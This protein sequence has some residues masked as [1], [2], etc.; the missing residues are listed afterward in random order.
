MTIASFHLVRERPGR[1]P[2]AMARLATDRIRLHGVSGLRFRRLLGTGRGDDTAASIDPRRTAMFAV[3]EDEEALDRF[4]AEHPVATRWQTAAEA[5]HVRLRSL[6]GHGSWRRYPVLD[7]LTPGA[8]GGPVAILTRADVGVGSWR[9]FARAGRPVGDEVRQAEGL[10]A[11]VGIGETPVGR[12]GT[13]SL[14]SSLTAA[15][16]FAS[17]M[18]E[19]RAV[20]RRARADG[21]YREE[22]FARFEPF[23]A[24]GTWD[25]RNPLVQR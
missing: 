3:W 1:A 5:W 18:P 24:T 13:F 2:V 15:I 7:E 6:G 10:L 23:A 19:H 22:L 4:Q 8:A 12:L 11:V 14:W 21:W 20:V 16:A 17:E 9:S 25:G